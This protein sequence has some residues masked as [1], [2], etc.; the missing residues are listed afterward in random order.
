MPKPKYS[1]VIYIF[2][3]ILVSIFFIAANKVDV[4]KYT[5]YQ[6]LVWEIKANEG[7]R[8]WWYR[9]GRA[10]IKGTWKP[11]YSIGFGWNDYGGTRR[12]KI[13]KYTSDGKVT[14][15]EALK[16]TLSEISKWGKLHNDPYKNLALQLYSYNCGYTTNGGNLGRCHGG[17][18]GCGHSCKNN[19]K[20]GHKCKNVRKSH[21]RRRRCELALWNH[22][23]RLIQKYTEENREK[24]S[25]QL[26]NVRRR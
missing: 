16:I 17:K 13:R 20:G 22:D 12:N 15:D 21:T 10:K 9:D 2:S 24:V 7:Y 25:G 19:G 23:W 4:K 14:Y 8:S 26:I 5:P 1:N 6:I 3:W 18:H 11:S